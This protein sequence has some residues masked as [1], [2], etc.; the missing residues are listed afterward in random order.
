LGFV[1]YLFLISGWVLVL[2]ALL[3]LAG[4]GQRLAFVV[5]GLLVELL[6]LALVAQRYRALRS[7]QEGA[8]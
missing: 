6:G 2:A 4:A 8:R 1:S 5:A 3:L 7:P